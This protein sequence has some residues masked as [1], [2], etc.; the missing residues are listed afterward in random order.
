[1]EYKRLEF[2][3]K[4]DFKKTKCVILGNG[5]SVKLFKEHKDIFTI[6]VN[7]ICKF[8]SPNVLLLIDSLVRF[9][10]RGIRN[11]IEDIRSGTPDYYVIHD[12]KWNFP[13]ENTFE[14]PFGK[15]KKL[16]NLE[17]K[18]IVDIGLD[19][20]YV[21]L[22]LAYKMGFKKIAILGVDYTPNH[23]YVKD[24]EHELMKFDKKQELNHMYGVL[25]STLKEKGIE[26]YNL[27]PTSQ[28]HS[29][30][31]ISLKEFVDL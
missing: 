5:E 9:E 30:P 31:H 18:N 11:R 21:A 15:Y 23:F 28:I 25:Y 14:I 1:M 17:S 4:K 13:Q 26:M 22:Q 2:L 29:I 7:D 19:S 10:R 6:G 27:S 8:Y 20:P 12:K 16:A 3:C 24:G